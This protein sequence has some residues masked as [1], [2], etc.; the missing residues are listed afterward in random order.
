MMHGLRSAALSQASLFT[1]KHIIYMLDH[2]DHICPEH[3]HQ[4]FA[5][6]MH[7]CSTSLQRRPP[8]CGDLDANQMEKLCLITRELDSAKA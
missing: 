1:I 7:K 2:Q 6:S 3:R 4:L 5:L 8:K